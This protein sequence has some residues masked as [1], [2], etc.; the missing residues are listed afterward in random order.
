[1]EVVFPFLAVV[2]AYLVGSLSFAVIVSKGFG[3]SDPRTYGSKNPGATN[4]LRSGNKAAATTTLLLDAIKGWLPMWAVKTWGVAHGLG[5][6]T[7]AAVG[8][9]AFMGH[10]FPV[11]FKFKGGKGVATAAGMLFGVDVLMGLFTLATWVAVVAVSRF[12]SLGAIAAGVFAPAIYLFGSG[13]LWV[14]SG[15][16]TGAIVVMSAFLVWW[17]AENIS[18][19]LQG[20]ESKVGAKKS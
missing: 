19:L 10:L 18:R 5:D 11:F 7:L 4:V 17:H 6:V 16:M 15:P 20:K 2:G 8:L 9:A 12:S 3:L 1:M 14:G 13:E